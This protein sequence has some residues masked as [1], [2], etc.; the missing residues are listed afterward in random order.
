MCVCVCV[1]VCVCL[2]VSLCVFLC[3]CA[4]GDVQYMY[5]DLRFLSRH[6]EFKKYGE[7]TPNLKWGQI[8][9]VKNMLKCTRS[10]RFPVRPHPE[11]QTGRA[12]TSVWAHI[13]CVRKMGIVFKFR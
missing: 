10:D 13:L 11:V 1:C 8:D 5:L 3:E 6:R 4:P 2:C 12:R 7:Q 9:P